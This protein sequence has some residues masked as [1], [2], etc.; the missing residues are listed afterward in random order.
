M[1]LGSPRAP[2]GR[3]VTDTPAT[4]SELTDT[5]V[6]RFTGS[7]H[8]A[9]HV[10]VVEGPAHW[11][12]PHLFPPEVRVP[13]RRTLDVSLVIFEP[14]RELTGFEGA[15]LDLAE[16]GRRNL[17]QLPTALG[18]SAG[19]EDAHRQAMVMADHPDGFREIGVIADHDSEFAVTAESVGEQVGADVDVRSLLF[20]FDHL[21][22]LRA[23]RGR[24]GQAHPDC[25]DLKAPEVDAEM[26]NRGQGSEVEVLPVWLVGVIRPCHDIGGEV[27]DAVDLMFR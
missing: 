4:P 19:V 21:H 14:L 24:M 11:T 18:A 1:A 8:A 23:D 16:E 12:G 3:S 27:A 25:A 15:C 13:Q 6:D 22:R 26:W 17:L 2:L 5:E 9:G 7:N 20:H 10:P